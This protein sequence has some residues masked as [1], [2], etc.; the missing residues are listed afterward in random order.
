M[1][2]VRQSEEAKRKYDCFQT[3]VEVFTDRDK[4]G[5]NGPELL[6]LADIS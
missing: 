1:Q 4:N 6:C 5:A 3:E 2:E